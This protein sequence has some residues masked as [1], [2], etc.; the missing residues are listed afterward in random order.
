MAHRFWIWVCP[1]VSKASA[2][3]ITANQRFT[4]KLVKRFEIERA[5]KLK[6]FNFRSLKA[7]DVRAIWLA[8]FSVINWPGIGGAWNAMLPKVRMITNRMHDF[9]FAPLCSRS[10]VAFESLWSCFWAASESTQVWRDH[11]NYYDANCI[12][13]STRSTRYSSTRA[14]RYRRTQSLLVRFRFC[15]LERLAILVRRWSASVASEASG[16]S[17][18]YL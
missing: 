14:G 1:K 15:W 9:R 18:V 8:K 11:Q 17:I 7:D 3:Y 16:L 6:V 13:I 5:K 10:G 12:K 2:R 4:R